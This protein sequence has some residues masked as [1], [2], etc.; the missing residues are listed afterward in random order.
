MFTNEVLSG[1]YDPMPPV[2]EF[3]NI[4]RLNELMIV[5]PV[6]VRSVCGSSLSNQQNAVFCQKTWQGLRFPQRRS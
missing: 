1:R 6:L 3:P 2:T 4:E 5:G